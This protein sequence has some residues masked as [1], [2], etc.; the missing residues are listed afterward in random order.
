MRSEW[1]RR[2]RAAVRRGDGA[3]SARKPVLLAR[4]RRR[5]VRVGSLYARC[6]CAC[7]AFCCLRACGLR[8]RCSRTVWVMMNYSTNPPTLCLWKA[9]GSAVARQRPEK[10]RRVLN[11]PGPARYAKLVHADYASC[12]LANPF[13]V[14]RGGRRVGPRYVNFSS[15]GSSK[16]KAESGKWQ[17]VSKT[18]SGKWQA[19]RDKWQVASST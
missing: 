9:P 15:R 4:G 18:V 10:R 14:K 11:N 5:R 3:R 17:V 1:G 7:R 8:A 6:M 12:G 13:S 19:A 2:A 16:R